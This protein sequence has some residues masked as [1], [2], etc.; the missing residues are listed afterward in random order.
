MNNL[1]TIFSIK[2]LSFFLQVNNN[3]VINKIGPEVA[4]KNYFFIF[5]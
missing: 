2:N 5:L 3:K 4:I 1:L